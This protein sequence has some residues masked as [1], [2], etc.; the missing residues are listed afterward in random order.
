[1][2]ASDATHLAQFGTASLWPIYA[3]PGNLDT[4]FRLSPHTNSD[5]HWA[6][7][8]SLPPEVRDFI[9][10]LSGKPCSGELFTHCKRELV[11][12][13]W[14]ILL[15]EDF[16]KA[17]KEGVVVRCADGIMRRVYLRLFTYS[18]DYPEKMLM[19]SLPDQGLCIC[20]RCLIPKEQVGEMGTKHDKMRRENMKRKDDGSTQYDITSARSKIYGKRGLRVNSTAVEDLLK[21]SSQVPTLNAFSDIFAPEKFNKYQ[22]FVVDLLHEFELGVWKAILVHLI[23]IIT[24]IGKATLHE[25]DRSTFGRGTIRKFG[26]NVSELKKLAA[27]DYEDILQSILPVCEGLFEEPH[28]A[29]IRKLIFVCAEWHALAKLRMHTEFTLQRLEVAT[30]AVGQM[31]RKFAAVT[32]A[33]FETEELD[34]EYQA[35]KRRIKQKES[36]GRSQHQSDAIILQPKK[37]T[38]NYHTPKFHFLGDY[39]PTIRWFGSTA[40]YSTQMGERAHMRAKARYPRVSKATPSLGM[41]HLDSRETN[42]RTIVANVMKQKDTCENLQNQYPAG[43]DEIQPHNDPN[44][45]Y[46]ISLSRT[47]PFRYG[48]WMSTNQDDIATK[49]FYDGLKDYLFAR[50]TNLTPEDDELTISQ[51]QRDEVIIRGRVLY[52]H[53]TC[54]INFTT[55]D[56]QRSQDTINPYNGHS[57]IMLHARDEPSN[58]GYHP[59]WYARVIGIYHCLVRLRD[60]PNFQEIPL[61]WI[62]WFG[63][64]DPRMR[65]AVNPNFMDQVGFVTAEDDTDMFGFI[66][67]A[68]V[69]RAC[70]LI[71]AFHYGQSDLLC[72]RSVGRNN[73]DDLDYVHYY[74][75]R[76][77]DRD[78]FMRYLGGGIGHSIHYDVVSGPDPEPEE[79]EEEE[80]ELDPA[81]PGP[82]SNTNEDLNDE[83]LESEDAAEVSESESEDDISVVDESDDERVGPNWD[84]GYVSP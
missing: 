66:D 30:T 59:F 17:Y 19:L 9:H 50:L 12:S 70:H 16:R 54:R 35:R 7:I 63:R 3:F 72:P 57:D 5:E 82:Q 39:A 8:P 22:I 47:H 43:I 31:V 25:F 81:P 20:P 28:S 21:K 77:V 75:N 58:P 83:E 44:V 78:M 73:Q 55:Y 69:I 23:R 32:C 49:G 61:L 60:T 27:R 11:Q 10:Q 4:L 64:S 71:P 79:P 24:K 76:F 34:Q 33:E 1:M 51:E 48:A 15:D 40:G 14:H 67:P 65:T 80:L 42:M 29:I 36:N 68:N 56:M 38:F 2:I 45:K 6:Y 46:I 13:I 37:K 62:R 41:T 26:H 84:D 52:C 74:V 18:A 53:Q